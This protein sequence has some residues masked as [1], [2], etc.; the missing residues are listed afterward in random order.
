M[1]NVNSK[2]LAA[3]ACTTLAAVCS[4]ASTA[5]AEEVTVVQIYDPAVVSTIPFVGCDGVPVTTTFTGWLRLTSAIHPDGTANFRLKSQ[6][7]ATWQQDGVDYTAD[8]NFSL[9]ESTRVGD[10]T[11]VVTNGVGS[12]SDGSRVRMHDVIHVT[13]DADG[14]VIRTFD[15]GAAECG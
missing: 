14:N 9:S 11:T 8:V 6:E 7:V 1:F 3:A 10:V 5:S 2:R 15:R 4:W 12:G 13:I